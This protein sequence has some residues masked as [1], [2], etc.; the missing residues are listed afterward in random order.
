[1]LWTDS[2]NPA[3]LSF[4]LVILSLSGSLRHCSR[5]SGGRS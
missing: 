2:L 4:S 3:I 5:S 1:L